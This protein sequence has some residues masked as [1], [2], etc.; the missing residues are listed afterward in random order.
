[1]G[2]TSY[3]VNEK[4]VQANTLTKKKKKSGGGP[5]VKRAKQ[6]ERLELC[7]YCAWS[8]CVTE[9][10]CIVHGLISKSPQSSQQKSAEQKCNRNRSLS[11]LDLEKFQEQLFICVMSA[12]NDAMF[13]CDV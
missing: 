10:S 12:E 11:V 7:F 9:P 3:T 5:N 13:V 4:P 2:F 1:M 6:R 8:V